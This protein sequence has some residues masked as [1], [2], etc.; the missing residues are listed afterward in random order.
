MPLRT[1]M[2]HGKKSKLPT[3]T[4]VWKKWI[5]T[6][7]EDFEGFRDP[8][9]EVTTDVVETARRELER[10]PEDGTELLQSHDNT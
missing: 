6:I 4:G 8:V 3:Q 2:I 10:E 5:P 9:E 7:L 1:F